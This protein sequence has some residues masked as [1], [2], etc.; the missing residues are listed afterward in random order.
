M[1]QRPSFEDH[2]SMDQEERYDFEREWAWLIQ[3][4]CN[5]LFAK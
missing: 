1:E 3:V 5:L 4:T 2:N